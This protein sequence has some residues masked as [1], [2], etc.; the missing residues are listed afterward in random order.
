MTSKLKQY[1][2][3]I[4]TR[5]EVLA[6][7]KNNARLSFIFYGWTQQRQEEFLDVCTGMR[8]VKIL[9]DSFFKAILNPDTHPERLSELLS[10]L[11]DT[12]VKILR[13]RP[14]ESPRITDETSLLVMDIIVELENGS[15]ANVEVQKIG[16]KFPGERCACYSSDLVLRQYADVRTEKGRKFNYHDIKPVYTIVFFENSPSEFK[17]FPDKW[18]HY[19][20]QKSDTG[21]E[22]ELIQKYLFVPL[23]I[24]K[25]NQHNK[26]V[27]SRIDAWLTFLC[28][29]DPGSISRLINEYPEFREMYEEVY[30]ICRSTERVM[31]MFSKELQI[32]DR[33][34]VQLMIDEMQEEYER[35]LCELKDKDEELKNKIEKLKDKD[36][37]LKDKDEELRDKDAELKDKA[38]ELKDK[39]AELKDKDAELKDKNEELKNK[40]AELKNIKEELKR[41]DRELAELKHQNEEILKRLTRLEGK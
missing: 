5:Q 9:Y 1:F 34:T 21:L 29:D 22:I 40:D 26:P 12:R 7:I 25:E 8:G 13:I 20:Q 28:M 15:L 2:P 19:F 39:D 11:L 3:L 41:K 27:K 33:N 17:K 38:A 32:L 37:E 4:R 18:L 6:D 23:D 16:Y 24:F 14:L 31:E 36:A 35:K 30:D 10:L